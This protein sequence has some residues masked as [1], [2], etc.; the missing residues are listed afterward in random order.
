MRHR[1][2]AAASKSSPGR[3]ARVALPALG[4]ATLAAIVLAVAPLVA[5]AAA[6]TKEPQRCG[7]LTVP[8]RSLP[9]TKSK[10][11]AFHYADVTASGVTCLYARSLLRELQTTTPV[12]GWTLTSGERSESGAYPLEGVLR[13]DKETVTFRYACGGC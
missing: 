12:T 4:T 13:H 8:A 7:S 11:S 10:S 5:A 2:S 6:S 9:G 3:L 1:H